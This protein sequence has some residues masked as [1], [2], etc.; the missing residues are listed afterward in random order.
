MKFRAPLPV[1][2]TT[3][4]GVGS[5]V[6]AFLNRD[7]IA[8]Q[9]EIQAAPSFADVAAKQAAAEASRAQALKYG[10]EAQGLQIK[11]DL[12]RNRSANAVQ[13]AL[14]AAGAVGPARQALPVYRDTG[15][16]GAP[17]E[18]PALAGPP[19]PGRDA[20]LSPAQAPAGV[21]DQM[22]RAFMSTL[23]AAGLS[24]VDGGRG[25]DHRLHRPARCGAEWPDA[26]VAGGHGAGCAEGDA[27]VLRARVRRGRQLHGRR[28]RQRPGGAAVRRLPPVG[29]R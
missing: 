24:S 28:E 1:A 9:A 3:A 18:N 20:P 5:L 15:V 11:N 17:V 4:N 22:L 2:Q 6:A 21:N 26:G 7:Q 10:Q 19:E 23:A 29:D 16:W 14:D 13:A 12:Q 27:A 25:A 8:Q